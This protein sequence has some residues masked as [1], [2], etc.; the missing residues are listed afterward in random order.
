MKVGLRTILENK[1]CLG[2]G[3]TLQNTNKDGLGYVQDLNKNYCM[4]CF[5]LKNYGISNNYFPKPNLAVIKEN[6]ACF[7]ISSVMHLDMLFNYPVHRYQP[8][9]KY[10]YLINQMDL[11]PKSTNFDL[12]MENIIKKATKEKIP[13]YD[14]I[15]LSA[16]CKDD[17][18]NLSN[19]IEMLTETDIY[20]LGV[21][22]S[23]KTTIYKGLTKDTEALAISKAGLTQENLVG[24]LNDKMIIDMPGLYQEGYLHT[25]LEYERYKRLLPD[26]RIKPKIYQITKGEALILEG[27]VAIKYLNGLDQTFVFYINNNIKIHK[28]NINRVEDLLKSDLFTDLKL[29]NEKKTFKI[30]DKRTQVTFG[31]MGFFQAVTN[32]LIEVVYPKGLSVTITEA[33]FK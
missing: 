3:A 19:Y 17:I 26:K 29:E 25:F 21:Q 11:L 33:L 15:F 7:L 20:L 28:T 1:K 12:L 14:I 24:K 6:S 2:C 23:G 22:N 16:L 10:I 5:K 32:G 4:E 18:S 13:Y 9:A 31:D 8:N 27:L 30:P